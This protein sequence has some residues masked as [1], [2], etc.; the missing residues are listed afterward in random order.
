MILILQFI[1]WIIAIYGFSYV[2][3]ES[4][5]G[6]EYRK[7]FD[8]KKSSWIKDKLKYLSKCVVCTSF[9]IS[10]LFSLLIYSPAEVYSIPLISQIIMNGFISIGSV[11][12]IKVI[13]TKFDMFE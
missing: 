10:I 1:L 5:M 9:Y 8:F 13:I 12:L 4:E 7:L 2:L 11:K 3:T 6:A